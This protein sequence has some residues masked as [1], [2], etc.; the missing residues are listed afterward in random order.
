[1]DADGWI[2]LKVSMSMSSQFEEIV[3]ANASHYDELIRRHGGGP[4]ASQYSDQATQDRRLDILCEIG[5][6]RH[7]HV[8]DFGCGTGR[9]LSRLRARGFS[10]T[11]TGYDVAPGVIEAAKSKHPDVRF[12]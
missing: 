2:L 8:L 3:Q 1:M 11:Y 9:L 5:D 4:A 10:G 6:I 12:E 7:S